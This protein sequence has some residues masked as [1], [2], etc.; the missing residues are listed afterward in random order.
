MRKS[1]KIKRMS[2]SDQ[3]VRNNMEFPKT[4]AQWRDENLKHNTPVSADDWQKFKRD[5]IEEYGEE[6]VQSTG[7]THSDFIRYLKDGSRES[8]YGNEVDH[9][10]LMKLL[11]DLKR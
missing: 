9:M 6:P 10:N 3:L 8:G 4:A 5:F 1:K 2:A 7:M 11:N